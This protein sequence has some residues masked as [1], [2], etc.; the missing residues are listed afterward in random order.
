[1]NECMFL[2]SMDVLYE[3][4]PYAAYIGQHT[5]FKISTPILNSIVRAYLQQVGHTTLHIRT[6]HPPLVRKRPLDR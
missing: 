4:E 1:M 5:D 2:L 3:N 6:R